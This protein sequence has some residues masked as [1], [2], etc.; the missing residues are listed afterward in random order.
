MS[1]HSFCI[2]MSIQCSACNNCFKSCF[3]YH[4]SPTAG[5]GR[6]PL[7]LAAK[8]T[9]HN[10]LGL[11]IRQKV[12]PIFLQC[13]QMTVLRTTCPGPP[14]HC[15]LLCCMLWCWKGMQKAAQQSRLLIATLHAVVIERRATSC[16]A[17]KAVRL[18]QQDCTCLHS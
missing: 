4:F 10:I 15:W 6:F 14:S 12:R 13:L 3:R 7:S 2:P 5:H 18:A 11:D 9:D 16:T 17:L 1:S 8:L